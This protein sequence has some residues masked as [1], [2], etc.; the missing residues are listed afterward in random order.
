MNALT[1]RLIFKDLYLQRGLIGV[2]TVAGLVSLV[3]AAEGRM[4]FNIGML[5]WI[6]AVIAFGIMVTFQ[7]VVNERKERAQLF[8][9]SLPLSHGDYVRT[10][11]LALLVC[12]LPV[13]L[14]LSGG[15]VALLF[16]MPNLPDGMVPFAV[17]LCVYMLANFAVVLSGALHVTSEGA[18]TALIAVTNMCVSVFIFMTFAVPGISGPFMGATPSWNGT[19]W[20]ILAI[21]LFVFALA[22]CL[23]YFVAARRRDHL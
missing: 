12:Y 5:G 1:R 16:I 15:A 23:P 9:L 6:T 18:I 13:W 7:G 3:I 21:E 10:K 2:S 11:I 20:I 8:V 17:L 19:F 22:L 14:V 4:R